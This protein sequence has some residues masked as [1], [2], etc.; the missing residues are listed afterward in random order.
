MLGYWEADIARSEV[1]DWK[2]GMKLGILTSV[3]L[4]Y[5]INAAFL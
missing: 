1:N 3:V 5:E 4:R 2:P